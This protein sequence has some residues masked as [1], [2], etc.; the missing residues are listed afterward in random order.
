[1]SPPA[2]VTPPMATL[3]RKPVAPLA[4]VARP[5]VVGLVSLDLTLDRAV[6]AI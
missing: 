6:T 5:R 4:D 2:L 3:Q 1:M